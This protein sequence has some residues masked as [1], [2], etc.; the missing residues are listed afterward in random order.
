MTIRRAVTGLLVLVMMGCSSD[1]TGGDSS[2]RDTDT[3]PPQMQSLPELPPEET[4]AEDVTVPDDSTVAILLERAR[5]HYLSAMSAQ[6]DGDSMRSSEQFEEAIAILD[7]LSLVPSIEGSPEF[8]DLSRAVIEDYEQYIARI[9]ELGPESSVFALREKLNQVMAEADSTVEEGPS[10]VVQGTTVPL[11]VNRVV[12][13]N[14]AFFQGKGREHMERW[15]HV[16]GLYF[17]MM[18]SIFREEEVPEEIVHLA[19]VESGLNPRARSWARAVGMW[20]FIKGTGRL[21]GLRWNY[22]YDE[23]RDFEKSTRAA[24]RHLRDL[25][26][27]FG[28]WYLAMAAYNSG[29]GRIYRG[30]RRSASTDFWEMRR[31]LPRETRNYVPQFIAVTLIFMDPGGYGFPG[32]EPAEALEYEYVTIDDCVDLELLAGCAST[33]VYVLRDLNPELTQ[34]CTPPGMTGYRLRIPKGGSGGFAERYAAIPDDKKRDWV[35]HRVKRGDTLSEIAQRYGVPVGILQET[36][37]IKSPRSLR[38]GSTLAVPVP[39]GSTRFAMADASSVSEPRRVK[40]DRSRV[41]RALA[42]ATRTQPS[43]IANMKRL[44]YRV[45]LGDTLGHIAEW[46]E[47]RAAELRNWNDIPYGS[48]IRVDQELV[49]WV[50]ADRA[51][52]F[53]EL[54]ELTFTAK[55][56]RMRGEAETPQPTSIAS[57]GGTLY[58]IKPGDTLEEIAQRQGVSVQQLK[59]WNNLSGSRIIAGRD[60]IIYPEAEKVRILGADE[61]PPR[62]TSRNESIIYVV[63]RGDTLWDIARAHDV[64]PEAL[65][66]WNALSRSRIYAGQEL[67]I[68]P[69]STASEQ[70]Q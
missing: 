54:D 42:R 51:E 12:E 63:K 38:V 39:K 60:L 13:Q 67:I 40:V 66:S 11:M 26:E 6:V 4:I 47:C 29:A 57:K 7:E 49:V 21:Y 5:Q 15:L 19:M 56:R 64:T 68:Y 36:N 1:P 55:Q 61:T 25:Y 59:G 48:P 65:K 32:I 24:A 52:R 58:R 8:N 37:N 69:G 41:D 31:Y 44:V 14:I 3:S 16:S 23:R 62:I 17:S 34:W 22:W 20:Q 45:K 53:A 2:G 33:N 50:P 35:V 70:R 43:N 27:E 30:I 18:K 10:R 28:D 46:Y 9:D